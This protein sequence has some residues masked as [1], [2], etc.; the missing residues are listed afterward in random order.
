MD[1]GLGGE[2]F[3]DDEELLGLEVEVETLPLDWRVDTFSMTL[4]ENFS[5][6][7]SMIEPRKVSTMRPFTGSILSSMT[8]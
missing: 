6:E 5:F 7:S 2:E 1:V 4:L 3:L 8:Y